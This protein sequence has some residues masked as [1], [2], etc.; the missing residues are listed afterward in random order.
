LAG[1][2]ARDIKRK[3]KSIQN[4]QQITQAMQL[5]STAKLKRSR[6]RLDKTKPYFET[7]QNT[8]EDIFSKSTDVEHV[9]VTERE[10]K[11][12]LYIIVTADRGLCGGYNINAMKMVLNQPEDKSNL[13]LLTIGNKAKGFFSNRDYEIVESFTGISEKPSY[14]DAIN[15]GNRATALFE[16]G[17]VDSVKLVYTEFVSTISQHPKTVQLLPVPKGGKKDDADGEFV[18]V[19]YEPSHQVV[20][21]YVIPKFVQATIYGAL[22]ESSAS[23]QG[24]RRV[25]MENATDNAEDMLDDLTLSFNQARQA[26]ITQEI[27]EIVGGAEALG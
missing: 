8:I 3:I 23:E 11:K 27:T 7:I 10:V 13:C 16:S 22:V 26:A 19:D 20:L 24:A 2:G 9:Y 4:T 1:T 17:E 21:D 6:S 12:T 18:Y 14:A 25:A 15:I 5:V